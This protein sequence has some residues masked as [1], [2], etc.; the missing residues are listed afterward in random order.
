[1]DITAY[2]TRYDALLCGDCALNTD[3]LLND[4]A[5][6]L[7]GMTAV[8]LSEVLTHWDEPSC[9]ECKRPLRALVTA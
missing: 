9:E 7:A 1:M 6:R 5:N 8:P 3:G 2:L 4:G